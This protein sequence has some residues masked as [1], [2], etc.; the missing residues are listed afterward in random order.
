MTRRGPSRVAVGVAVVSAA[1][2]VVVSAALH[3][4]LTSALFGP[5]RGHDAMPGLDFLLF[6]SAGLA[7]VNV[8]AV[9]AGAAAVSSTRHPGTGPGLRWAARLAFWGA[10]TGPL[11]VLLLALLYLGWHALLLISRFLP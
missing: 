2:W 1:G 10:M 9:V 7:F 6:G 4:R 3:A 8:P 5:V 11:E